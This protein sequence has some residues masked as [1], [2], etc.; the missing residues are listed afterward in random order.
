[1]SY[2]KFAKFWFTFYQKRTSS[3]SPIYYALMALVGFNLLIGLFAYNLFF[4]FYQPEFNYFISA[5]ILL[6]YLGIIYSAHLFLFYSKPFK[7]KDY[8]QNDRQ[9]LSKKEV[10]IF[11]IIFFITLSSF[12]VSNF[13]LP[14][15]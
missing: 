8:L 10:L 4:F 1:M 7:I 3:S 5:Y 13:F 11:R 6:G 15:Q 9:H 14:R 2:K 12:I